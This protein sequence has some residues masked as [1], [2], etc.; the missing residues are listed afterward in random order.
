MQ[1]E[2]ELIKKYQ[3]GDVSAYNQL[4]K[5]HLSNTVG[6]FF[7]ITGDRMSAE[8]L[9]QD[10]FFKLFKHLKKFQFK[11]AFS[12]YLYRVNLNTANTWLKRNR[13][14]NILHLDQAP[15]HGERDTRIEDEW[16]RKELWDAIAKL[17]KKQ[18]FVVIMRVAR[19]MPYKEI[20]E[21]TNMNE[22]TAKVNFH[23]ALKSLKKWLN[24]D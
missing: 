23:H 18:R 9:A 7:N 11:S 19:G 8:D 24:N 20:A 6:F 17:P 15:D 12:T 21:I 22:G 3:D 10:V 5:K 13:W 16:T 1:S 2:H 4:V 14:K